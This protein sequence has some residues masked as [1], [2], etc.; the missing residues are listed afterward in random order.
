[1]AGALAHV[2]QEWKLFKHDPPGPRFCNHRERMK[3]RSRTHGVIAVAIGIV[4]LA[5]GFVLLFM[6]GPGIPLIVFGL[7]L[8]AAHSQRLSGFLDTG[9]CR[10]RR[11]GRHTKARWVAMSGASRVSVIVAIGAVVGAAMMVMWK[12]V[13]STYVLDLI[14]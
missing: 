8:I 12:F 10:L 1:M 5:G 11:L 4:L 13:V 14:R 9:E 6:P 7:A 2:K 3:H